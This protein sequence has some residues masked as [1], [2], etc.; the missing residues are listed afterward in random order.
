MSRELGECAPIREM[1]ENFSREGMNWAQSS[2]PHH[3]SWLKRC[4][5]NSP[6]VDLPGIFAP[7][8]AARYASC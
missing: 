2:Q 1:C 8:F 6:A 5:L 7:R 4:A 3:S